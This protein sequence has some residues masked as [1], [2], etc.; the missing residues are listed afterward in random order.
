MHQLRMNLAMKR[1][2]SSALLS[3]LKAVAGGLLLVVHDQDRLAISC[4]VQHPCRTRRLT[5]AL[6][7][8]IGSP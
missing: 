8:W 1:T 6:P 3:S 5:G 2:G 4:A 7:G